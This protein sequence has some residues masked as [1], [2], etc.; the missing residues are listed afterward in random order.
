MWF[1]SAIRSGGILLHVLSIRSLKLITW[2]VRLLFLSL[3]R[4]EA[5]LPTVSAHWKRLIP[6][7]TGKRESYWTEWTRTVSVNGSVKR[8]RISVARKGRWSFSGFA[9]KTWHFVLVRV[10][11]PGR[12][13][14]SVGFFFHWPA[15]LLTSQKNFTLHFRQTP[16]RSEKSKIP[17]ARAP[18]V[19]EHKYLRLM[20]ALHGKRTAT[21]KIWTPTKQ[22]FS[23]PLIL[24]FCL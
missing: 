20:L 15:E 5:A 17:L 13:C 14:R 8:R 2:Q 22:I 16:G 23:E 24:R 10:R 9:G 1:W 21:L 12:F 18:M 19:T 3:H 11:W 7:W 6:T 4:V